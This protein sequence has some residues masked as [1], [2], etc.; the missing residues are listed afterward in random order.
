LAQLTSHDLERKRDQ[1][2]EQL[3]AYRQAK[4]C[5]ITVVFDGWRGGWSTEKK[6]RRRGI[7]LIFSRLGETADEV[8]KRLAKQRGASAWVVTSDREIANYAE[9][10]AVPVIPS[11]QFLERMELAP[12]R[13]LK[14]AQNGE[15]EEEK[16][17]K[18]KGPSRRLSKKSRRL[19]SALKKL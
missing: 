13:S 18:R 2:I 9:R 10:L 15:A 17:A 11:D 7:D 5:N 16:I 12:I 6:E 4:P 14:D 8:I 19:K 1:L 3:S